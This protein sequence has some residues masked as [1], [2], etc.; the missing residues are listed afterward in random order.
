MSLKPTL[1]GINQL[2][3]QSFNFKEKRIA[4]VC[5]AASV[6]NYGVAT[7]IALLKKGFKIVRLFTPEHG[8][9]AAGVDGQYQADGIDSKTGVPITSLYGNNFAPKREDFEG[10]DLVVFDLPD[11]GCRFYTYLWTMTYIMEACNAFGLPLIIA[12]RP[13]PIGGD[14]SQAEGPFLDEQNCSSFIGR[15]SIPI[16]HSCTLGELARYFKAKEMPSLQ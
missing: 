2:L 13:N 11:I 16:R 1:F 14:L 7:R 4:L 5:N 12:D 15:W 9:N 3:N 10:V 8:L 6:T